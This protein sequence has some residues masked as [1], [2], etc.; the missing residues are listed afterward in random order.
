MTFPIRLVQIQ[1]QIQITSG[2]GLT[3]GPKWD[4]SYGKIR[5]GIEYGVNED[6][7]FVRSPL[8]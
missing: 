3:K 2:W 6:G 8:G 5:E 7:I 4:Y 1:T